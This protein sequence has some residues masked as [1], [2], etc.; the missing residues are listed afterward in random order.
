MGLYHGW[1]CRGSFI[2]RVA[3]GSRCLA[4]FGCARLLAFGVLHRV[5][6][7]G[8]RRTPVTLLYPTANL[9]GTLCVLRD[10]LSGSPVGSQQQWQQPAC[11]CAIALA[12]FK[13]CRV[14]HNAALCPCLHLDRRVELCCD[15]ACYAV[16]CAV[17][18]CVCGRLTRQR[19]CSCQCAWG[20]QLI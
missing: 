14:Q 8:V 7:M 16:L 15:T 4:Y 10:Q 9:F 2:G 20:L 6:V 12:W 5:C 11:V 1:L 3:L 18:C 17:L 13:L 19:T